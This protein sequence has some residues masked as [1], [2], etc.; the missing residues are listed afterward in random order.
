L[1]EEQAQMVLAE[2]FHKIAMEHAIEE[3]LMEL[4]EHYTI[5]MVHLKS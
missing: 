3:Q 1:C 4:S 2:Q 5:V